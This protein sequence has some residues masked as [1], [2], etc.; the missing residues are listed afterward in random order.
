MK[1]R[2]S[3]LLGRMGPGTRLRGSLRRRQH[4]QLRASLPSSR[5]QRTP[6]S[7]A[8]LARANDQGRFGSR[9]RLARAVKVKLITMPDFGQYAS[10]QLH[11][12]SKYTR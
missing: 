8:H 5:H 1:F 2:R 6:R 3:V 11:R 4:P 12:V 9:S 10:F 7:D